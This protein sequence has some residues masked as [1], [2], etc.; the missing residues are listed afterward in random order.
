MS[1]AHAIIDG[2][3]EVQTLQ[4]GVSFVSSGRSFWVSNRSAEIIPTPVDVSSLGGCLRL[5]PRR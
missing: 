3:T 4:S 1:I 5:D 2:F